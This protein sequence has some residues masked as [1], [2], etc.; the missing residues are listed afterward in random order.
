MSTSKNPSSNADYI[1]LGVPAW[2]FLPGNK[3]WKAKNRFSSVTAITNFDPVTTS[4]KGSVIELV[5][6]NSSN[7]LIGFD[8]GV[9]FGKST[10]R[11]SDAN[12][13][14]K[15]FANKDSIQLARVGFQI[16]GERESW[17]SPTPASVQMGNGINSINVGGGAKNWETGMSIGTKA[18]LIG[19]SGKDTITAIG[20]KLGISIFGAVDL[21]KGNDRIETAGLNGETGLLVSNNGVL[22]MGDGDDVIIG[23]AKAIKTRRSIYVNGTIDMGAGNDLITGNSLH[24]N[25]STGARIL[26]GAGKDVIAAPLEFSHGAFFDFGSGIDKLTLLPGKYSV[27]KGLA[28]S[29]LVLSSIAPV[30]GYGG[31]IDNIPINGLE[32]LVSSVSGKEYAFALGEI[33]IV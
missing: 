33:Q 20:N 22:R 4:S 29:Q 24:V 17:S 21:G 31:G 30:G 26:M 6:G 7:G 32:F 9:T 11:L 14:I 3:Y 15:I 5:V 13:Q 1:A 28:G 16:L 27:A 18:S 2:G 25:S 23:T 10:V 19:G 12:D 8:A